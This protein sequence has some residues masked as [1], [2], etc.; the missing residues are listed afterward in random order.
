MVC[1]F[2]QGGGP[3]HLRETRRAKCPETG[4][5]HT[6]T[7]KNKKKHTPPPPPPPAF[8]FKL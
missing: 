5:I 2:F 4:D 8:S 7:K 3:P 6:Q 1:C